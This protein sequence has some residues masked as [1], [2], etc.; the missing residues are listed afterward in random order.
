SRGSIASFIEAL[1][2]RD[3][4]ELMTFNQSP[5]T[6]FGQLRPATPETL[7]EATAFLASQRARGGTVLRHALQAAYQYATPDRPLN[8]VLMS[9]GM[10]EQWGQHELLQ[11][12][13]Q[14]PANATVFTVGVGN[15]VNRPLLEQLAE[16]AGGV[17]AFLSEGDDLARQAAA[18]RRKLTRPAATGLRLEVAGVTAYDTTPAELPS[19]YHGKPV[20]VYGRYRGDGPF[21]IRLKAEVLGAPYAQ[22]AVLPPSGEDNSEI[23]RMWAQQ[24]I[25][26][27]LKAADRAGDRSVVRPQV[28]S[29]AE[30]Y[31]IITEYTSF[32][33]LE[34]DQEYR[35]WKIDRKNATRLDRDH[36]SRESLE[37]RL[38]ELREQ[39]LAQLG[40]Q[41]ADEQGEQPAPAPMVKISGDHTA[42]EAP[43]PGT[44]L[45]LLLGL[46]PLLLGRRRRR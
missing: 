39:S 36:K 42:A 5:T 32:I 18:F 27:L 29:L 7:A 1:S 6:L 28:V 45:L 2:P 20:R 11:L 34:N 46:G 4:V 14:R 31:S 23:E 41:P 13:R 38:E 21:D 25:E 9:D 26:S 10:T 12:L 22:S 19:L 3:R 40:P 30:A 37:R 15:E 33:V 16:D 35:R 17:A 24:K 8:V 44:A 43:E